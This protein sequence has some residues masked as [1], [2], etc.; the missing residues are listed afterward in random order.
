MY[1]KQNEING[2]VDISVPLVVCGLSNI[3]R[4]LNQNCL[5]EIFKKESNYIRNQSIYQL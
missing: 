1:V 4:F 2:N 5:E 3:N